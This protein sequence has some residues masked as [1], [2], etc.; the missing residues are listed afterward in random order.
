MTRKRVRTTKPEVNEPILSQETTNTEFS[1]L[2]NWY[3]YNKNQDDAKSYFLTYLKDTNAEVFERLKTKVSGVSIAPTVGW[4]C[5]IFT[6]N[7]Q[8]FPEK[9]LKTI[10]DEAD[11][12]L[13]VVS[14]KDSPK[15]VS[16]SKRPG[17]Q[18]NLQNQLRDL[19]GEID[20]E[21]DVFMRNGCASEFC[22]YDWLK[23]NNIKHQQAKNIAQYYQKHVLAELKEA[24]SGECEQL[25][26]AYS[27]LT[28]QQIKSFITFVNSIIEGCDKWSDVAKQISMTNKA[29]RKKKTKPPLKQ[30]EK[31]QYAKEHGALKSIPP[32]QIVGATQLWVYNTKYKT[33]G[34][35]V[36]NNAHGFMVKGCTILNF[37]PSESI[38]KTLRQPETVIPTV[39]ES[40]KVALRKVL[41]SLRTKEKK[42]TGRINKDTILLRVL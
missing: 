25:A 30:V 13:Q 1:L 33:L 29:P 27:F 32:T 39:L 21:V 3:T 38:G 35:Y 18:E 41:V 23:S 9:Y 42:L 28:R 2:L 26:E 40:G 20:F 10:A 37:D 34:V 6:L 31:L 17:V 7:Q 12:V 14:D 22:M 15:D 11:R 5:R 8:L 24:Y 19:L 36:C 16:V 4:L